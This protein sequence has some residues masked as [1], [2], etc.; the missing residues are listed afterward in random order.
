MSNHNQG[1]C[2]HHNDG[3]FGEKTDLIFAILS[4]V[5]LFT[6]FLLDQ[7]AELPFIYIL[8]PYLISYGFGGYY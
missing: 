8:V 6:G 3:V 2:T 1:C 5:F 4:G 7:F